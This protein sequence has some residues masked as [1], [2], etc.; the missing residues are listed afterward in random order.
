MAAPTLDQA[1]LWYLS[2]STGL[3]SFVLLTAATAL[4]V[5]AT[6]RAL[7]HASWPRF[8]RSP[9]D[10]AVAQSERSPCRP[11]PAEHTRRSVR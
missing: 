8:A 1:P 4:G 3:T 6:Q 11:R 5:A 9:R 10:R 2:R 7:A